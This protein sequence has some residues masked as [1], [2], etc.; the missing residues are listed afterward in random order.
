M[1]M[2]DTSVLVDALTGNKASAAALIQV[3]AQGEQITLSSIVLYEWLRGP[4]SPAEVASQEAL[5]PSS[6]T[7]FFNAADARLGAE[8]YRSLKRARTREAGIAIAATAIRH[9]AHLWTL[10]PKD[11]SDILG[12][13]L[14]RPR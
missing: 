13:S 14:W 4:R 10:N 11:F 5:F 7:V 8:I 6:S 2:L 3:L 12:L 9:E 1:I